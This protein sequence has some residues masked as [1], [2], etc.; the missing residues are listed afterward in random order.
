MLGVTVAA[1]R[2]QDDVLSASFPVPTL[3]QVP[4][5][6]ADF[7]GRGAELDRMAAVLTITGGTATITSACGIG[8]A[9]KS[10]LAKALTGRVKDRFPTA[11]LWVELRGTQQEALTAAEIFAYVIRQF[12]PDAKLDLPTEFDDQQTRQAKA[13]VL[14]NRYRGVLAEASKGGPV[15]IVLDNARDAEQVRPLV[16]VPVP[17][18]FIITSRNAIPLGTKVELD[19][20]SADESLGLLV[21][22][23]G[24]RPTDE[25]DLLP[26]VV[27][28]CAR[29]PL[30]VRVAGNTLGCSPNLSVL[31]YIRELEVE[32]TLRLHHAD[33]DVEAVLALSARLLVTMDEHLAKRWEV[34][35][36]FPADFDAAAVVAVWHDGPPAND[37][38]GSRDELTELI[39][40]SLVQ[41]EA[42]RYRLHDLMRPV[43]RR[44]FE[45][46]EGHP[47]QVGIV[48]RLL[49]ADRRFATYY[50]RILEAADGLYLRDAA[51]MLE[52]LAVFDREEGEHPPRT[53]LGRPDIHREP[54]QHAR[55]RDMPRI[56]VER[57]SHGRPPSPR[58]REDSVA[59]GVS[60]GVPSTRRP[61][62]RGECVGQSW[63][64]VGSP[65]RHAEGR[66]ILRPAPSHRQ[67]DWRP[68]GRGDCVGQPGFGVGRSWG[69]AEGHRV[70]RAA[71]GHRQGDRRP[72]GGG[73]N[74]L[75]FRH[76]LELPRSA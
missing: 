16:Q 48:E 44:T 43:A 36:V 57:G 8:G 23:V 73:G 13:E 15:L 74:V 12:H 56:R 45:Y 54:E 49:A 22:L 60:C 11:Q 51:G 4:L 69:V 64:G 76:R 62:G 28:L 3:F 41:F 34:L 32:R 30:A 5:P 9:G 18:S 33:L 10:E 27:E 24:D 68:P 6:E 47:E 53:V 31:D 58:G 72:P 55:R 14:V 59:G 71:P 29:L 46:A 19:G 50:W 7:T 39:N 63:F 35:S 20:L 42:G 21:D 1:L 17:V 37:M 67:G 26:R 40:R 75:Q 2:L 25:I 52:G 38:R 66:R 70:L 61:L 65:R